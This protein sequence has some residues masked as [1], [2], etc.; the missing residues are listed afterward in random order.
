M[1]T[2]FGQNIWLT[3]AAQ[4]DRVKEKGLRRSDV[5]MSDNIIR[6]DRFFRI[7]GN[8]PGFGHPGFTEP[9]AEAR[10]FLYVAE[11]QLFNRFELTHLSSRLSPLAMSILREMLL[12][13]GRGRRTTPLT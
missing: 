11:G 5:V 12:R 10:A 1:K 13:L 3:P 9:Y 8:L 6:F 7:K 4:N 2:Q